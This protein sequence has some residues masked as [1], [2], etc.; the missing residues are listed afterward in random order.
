[1]RR[2]FPSTAEAVR[3]MKVSFPRLQDLLA[4]VSEADR[5]LAWNEIEQQPTSVRGVERFRGT[6]RVAYW[7]RDETSTDLVKIRHGFS[8]EAFVACSSL[9]KLRF[10]S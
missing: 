9:E 10:R 5:E 6:R 8:A 1:M 2:Y 4:K 7:S 3:E